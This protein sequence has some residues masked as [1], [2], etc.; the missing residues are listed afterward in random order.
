MIE[1]IQNLIIDI[2]QKSQSLVE[3]RTEMSD[4]P[5]NY[6]CV[7]AHTDNEYTELNTAAQQIGTVVKQTST[8]NVYQIARLQTSAGPLQ[9][10]KIRKPDPTR[11]E[12]GDADFTVPDYAAFKAQYLNQSG[13]SLIERPEM[14][15]IELVDPAFDVR[16]YFSHPTLEMQLGIVGGEVDSGSRPE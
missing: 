7:F 5:V 14:E 3:R 9:L 2:V 8:G 1:N 6:A 13:F 16:A 15:M 12:R 11:T 10:L 4:V